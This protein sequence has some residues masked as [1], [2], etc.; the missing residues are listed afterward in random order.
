LDLLLL[1]QRPL[2]DLHDLESTV[3]DLGL[4][5]A[6]ELDGLLAGI[7][8]RLAAKGLGIAL[9]VLEHARSGRLGRP[10]SRPRE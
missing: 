6:A 3:L 9:G 2:L 1:L 10:D 7:Y 5:P 8:L 4:D